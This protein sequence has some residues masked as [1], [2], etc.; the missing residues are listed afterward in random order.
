MG[1]DD[2]CRRERS[3]QQRDEVT[4]KGTG[5]EI[6]RGFIEG[7]DLRTACENAGEADAAFFAAGEA[8]G[9]ALLEAGESDLLEGF[10]DELI[11]VIG[12]EVE[13]LRPERD[14][15]ENGRAE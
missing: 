2:L 3:A 7:Q 14:I 1:G 4:A 13:L 15:V 8:V 9:R 11:Q 12:I 6:A 5:V 10:R